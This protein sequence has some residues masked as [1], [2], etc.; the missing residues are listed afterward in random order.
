MRR[1][2]QDMIED[3]L[4]T[5]LLDGHVSADQTVTITRVGDKLR[6]TSAPMKLV[7]TIEEAS[8]VE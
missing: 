5:A 8:A 6:L 4:A 2:I 1:A 3:P 7:E